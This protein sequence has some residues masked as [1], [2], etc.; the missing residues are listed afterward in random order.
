MTI[1]DLALVIPVYNEEECIVN[2]INGWYDVLRSLNC[3]FKIL[4]FNDGSK[5]R[6]KE[7][8]AQLDGI[9]EIEV[10]N[11]TN[12]GHGP[13][14]LQGYHHA[15]EIAHWVFQCDSDGEM[16][17]NSFPLLWKERNNFDALFGYRHNRIQPKSRRF[18]SAISRGI[19]HLFF[20][21][22]VYDVNTP[23]RLLRT[24]VL[25]NIIA[26]I[27]SN[28]FAPNILV[29]GMICKKKLRI[30]NLPVPHEP[31]KTGQVSIVKLGLLKAIIKALY[32]TLL[33]I[34]SKK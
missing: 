22:A 18:I 19:I 20:G 12:S 29:S 11:K 23:Y 32:Q 4:I 31:R 30:Y 5:D 9:Q 14:I 2:V 17:P 21:N 7:V 27:P 33:F 10:I 13:T 8:L 15:C 1:L 16:Q 6:T 28:T 3:T 34:V 25:K 26:T 24:D